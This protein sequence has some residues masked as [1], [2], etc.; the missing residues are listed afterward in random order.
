MLSRGLAVSGRLKLVK[1]EMGRRR[2]DFT[3]YNRTAKR[4]HKDRTIKFLEHGW[5]KESRERYKVYES[6]PKRLGTVSVCATLERE[7]KE[8]EQALKLEEEMRW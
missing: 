5:V 8:V 1:D 4:H 6:I 3:A 7:M 2:I